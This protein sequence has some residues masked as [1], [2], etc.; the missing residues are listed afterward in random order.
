MPQRIKLPATVK[1]RKSKRQKSTSEARR[2]CRVALRHFGTE[3]KAT[4]ALRLRSQG[5]FHKILKGQMKDTFEMKAAVQRANERGKH[6]W[7]MVRVQP[8]CTIDPASIRVAIGELNDVIAHLE[9]LLSP[10]AGSS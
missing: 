10:P 7:E 4:Y 1:S 6:A 2:L 9:S 3:R 8:E 5:A